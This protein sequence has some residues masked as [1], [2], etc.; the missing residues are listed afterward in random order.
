[1]NVD[2]ILISR[3]SSAAH[4]ACFAFRR[5]QVGFPQL[6]ATGAQSSHRGLLLGNSGTTTK[7]GHMVH[8]AH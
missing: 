1:M 4:Y 7:T 6:H 8:P 5:L 2:L 3:D